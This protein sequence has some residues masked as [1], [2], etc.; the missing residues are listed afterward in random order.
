MDK[1]ILYIRVYSD[2]LNNKILLTKIIVCYAFRKKYLANAIYILFVV[3]V[4]E[5]INNIV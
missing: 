1:N 2:S 5:T 3:N 4:W